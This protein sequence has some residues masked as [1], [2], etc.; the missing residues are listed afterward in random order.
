MKIS[1]CKHY[2]KN[3]AKP[4]ADKCEGGDPD[5][6]LRV[7]L[8]CGHVGCCDSNIF[9]HAKNHAKETGHAVM[10]YYPTDE[11]S[12]IWCYEHNDYLES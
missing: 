4:N 8:T 7:C 11:F 2:P 10:A 12:P 6:E 9:Q 1:D 3:P 5:P